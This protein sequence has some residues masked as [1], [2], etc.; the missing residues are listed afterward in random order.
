M[1]S[2]QIVP[3]YAQELEFGYVYLIG[4]ES[5]VE[6]YR[7]RL[8]EWCGHSSS[9]W[10]LRVLCRDAWTGG[11]VVAARRFSVGL[12]GRYGVVLCHNIARISDFFAVLEDVGDTSGDEVI[13]AGLG[14]EPCCDTAVESDP[15]FALPQKPKKRPRLRLPRAFGL[16]F[17]KKHADANDAFVCDETLDACAADAIDAADGTTDM[18][19]FKRDI[20]KLRAQIM[21]LIVKYHED[22]TPWLA[23]QLRGKYVLS[24]DGLSRLVVNGNLDIVLPDYDECIVKM[25]SSCKALYVLF[26][27]HTEGIVLKQ[28]ADYRDELRQIL[29]IVKDHSE[30]K[31]DSV[32]DNMCD[33]TKNVLNQKISKIKSAFRAKLPVGKVYAPYVVKGRQGGVYGIELDRTLVTLPRVFDRM[34][35]K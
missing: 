32:V 19:E 16:G 9:R 34:S 10:Q 15:V 35:A 17:V 30:D 28:M 33:S 13:Y 14:G 24:A 25:D 22:P 1:S 3:E 20:E 23:V 29:D 2:R 26:L 5:E 4:S 18:E 7:D 21:G 6:R 11:A 27:R 31:R 12:I 8:S